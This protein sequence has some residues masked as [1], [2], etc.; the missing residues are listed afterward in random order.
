MDEV[1]LDV[2]N[3]LGGGVAVARYVIAWRR[4]ETH[5]KGRGAAGVWKDICCLSRMQGIRGGQDRRR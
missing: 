3:I 2:A 1:G 4:S 5:V